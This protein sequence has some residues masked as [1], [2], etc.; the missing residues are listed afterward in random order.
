MNSKRT[1]RHE[2]NSTYLV[3]ELRTDQKQ[4]S[5]EEHLTE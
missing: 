2:N 5:M 4:R 3:N 1:L